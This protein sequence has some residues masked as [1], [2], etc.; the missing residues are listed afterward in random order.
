MIT[1]QFNPTRVR[2][3][4]IAH[5]YTKHKAR[6]GDVTQVSVTKL[7]R[8]MGL[9]VSMTSRILSDNRNPGSKGLIG[10]RH[11]FPNIDQMY[12][13]DS[14]VTDGE[15]RQETPQDAPDAT[16]GERAD[17][18]T[19]VTTAEKPACGDFGQSADVLGAGDGCAEVC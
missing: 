14:I 19:P 17:A 5:G 12:F 6:T 3:M 10:L 16:N 2:D 1:Y 13:F 9:S 4:A 15:Y 7:A 8:A 11:A 18:H